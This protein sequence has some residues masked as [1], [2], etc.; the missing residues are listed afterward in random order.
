[1]RGGERIDARARAVGG[2]GGARRWLVEGWAA[3]VGWAGL[4][5]LREWAGAEKSW[6][7]VGREG[8]D[9]AGRVGLLGRWVRL[10]W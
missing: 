6:V 3:R 7:G 4:E 5:A 2:R 10:G 9:W 8:K 1:M